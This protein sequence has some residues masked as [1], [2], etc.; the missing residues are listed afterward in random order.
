[1]GGFEG[2]EEGEREGGGKERER[3]KEAV[4]G[5]G[6]VIV[7]RG[8]EGEE[9]EEGGK[10]ELW[11]EN[12]EKKVFILGGG[13]GEGR[14][15]YVPKSC[16]STLVRRLLK[17]KRGKERRGGKEMGKGE[18]GGEGGEGRLFLSPLVYSYIIDNNLY[19]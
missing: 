1:M 3:Y 16:S 6:V 19:L 7:P 10:G 11:V 15:E 14:E 4:V 8:E 12:V 17:E 5:K 2:G 18:E 9:G 13:G